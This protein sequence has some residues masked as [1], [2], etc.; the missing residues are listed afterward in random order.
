MNEWL[1]LLLSLSP[2]VWPLAFL[3]DLRIQSENSR[4]GGELVSKGRRMILWGILDANLWIRT[5]C[6][7]MEAFLH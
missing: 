6:N 5:R 4:F 3:L 7:A 2:R 1:N